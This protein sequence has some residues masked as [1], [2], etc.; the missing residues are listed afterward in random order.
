MQNPPRRRAAALIASITILTAACSGGDSEPLLVEPEPTEE[1]LT[2]TAQVPDAV[3]ADPLVPPER[4]LTGTVDDLLDGELEGTDRA[5]VLGRRGHDPT[6]FTQGLV[7]D[8]DRLYESRGQ[9]GESALT[10]IDALT[11]RVLREAPLGEE[12]FAEGLALVED[13]LIQLT[14]QEEVAFVYDVETFDLVDQFTYEGEGWGLCYDG[15]DLWMSDGTSVLTRRDPETFEVLG[16]LEVRAEGVP[17]D[18]LNELECLDG[19]IWANVWL[20]DTIVVIEPEGGEVFATL[21]AS[22]LLDPAEIAAGADV[23]NGIA[24]DPV[25]DV[26]VITGKLWP[27]MFDIDPDV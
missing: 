17:V 15:F 25:E 19:A 5:E 23:L 9:Y 10:E 14:W 26:V 13:R 21:D 7:F 8:G 27:A 3:A 18:Q 22:G 16:E 20:S 11:G 1:V 12:F 4:Q 2:S 6:A 24:Y